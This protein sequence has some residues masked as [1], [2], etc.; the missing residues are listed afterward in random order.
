[1]VCFIEYFI[2][3]EGKKEK[4]GKSRQLKSGIREWSD[5]NVLRCEEGKQVDGTK[6]LDQEGTNRGIQ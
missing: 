4:K 6:N 2:K 5:N 3:K 1:L